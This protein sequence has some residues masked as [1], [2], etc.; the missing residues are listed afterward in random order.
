MTQEVRS[1]NIQ[2]PQYGFNSSVLNNNKENKPISL[3]EAI[4]A[5]H[6]G[7]YF[8]LSSNK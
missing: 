6:E 5:A 4:L 3:A 1:I 2:V 7:D 8:V